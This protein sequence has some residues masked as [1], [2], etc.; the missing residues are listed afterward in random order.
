MLYLVLAHL[1]LSYPNLSYPSS[2]C[3]GCAWHMG[4]PELGTP[5]DVHNGRWL[6][7]LDGLLMGTFHWVRWEVAL[8]FNIEKTWAS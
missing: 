4:A 3:V 8:N 5:T 1:V 2:S 6:T 7:T